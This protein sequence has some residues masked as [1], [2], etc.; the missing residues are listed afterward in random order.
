ME[1]IDQI[2]KQKNKE[3]KSMQE[4]SKSSLQKMK[5]KQLAKM[6]PSDARHFLKKYNPDFIMTKY[7]GLTIE[8]INT[9]CIFSD[10]PTLAEMKAMY[11]ESLPSA[12]L[13]AQL[14][15]LSEFC[16]AR[17]KMND[18]VAERTASIIYTH[19]YY[20]KASELLLFFYKFSTG[21][22]GHFYGSI[23][24]QIILNAIGAFISQERNPMIDRRET[25]E[26]LKRLEEERKNTISWEEYTRR[27]GQEGKPNPLLNI[28][29]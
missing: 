25:E 1:K 9:L 11:G 4:E 19:Y 12:W 3:L 26:R 13:M 23:D 21:R 28:Q 29:T 22:Y 2:L 20:L 7:K 27:T 10:T 14:F 24:P 15:A 16:G 8:D 18:M 6:T 17:D 5:G